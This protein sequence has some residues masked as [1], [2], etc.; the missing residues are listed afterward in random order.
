M[1]TK[2]L[3]KTDISVLVMEGDLEREK[4]ELILN[5]HGLN[6]RN[7][8]E[9]VKNEQELRARL[10]Y[11]EYHIVIG[12]LPKN[13]RREDGTT[14]LDLTLEQNDVKKYGNE[15]EKLE[16]LLPEILKNKFRLY[17]ETFEND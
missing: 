3:S 6:N 16:S 7:L 1:K 17:D 14:Y 9:I 5:H 10:N 8:R 15:Y 12:I 2:N 13:I 4:I 11:N